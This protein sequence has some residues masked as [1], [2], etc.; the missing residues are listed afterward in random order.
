MVLFDAIQNLVFGHDC[1]GNE[2]NPPRDASTKEAPK[3]ASPNIYIHTY[4]AT[5]PIAQG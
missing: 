2:N 4:G 3:Q 1:C 5:L